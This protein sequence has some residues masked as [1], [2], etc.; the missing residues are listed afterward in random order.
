MPHCVLCKSYFVKF[1]EFNGRP[2]AGCPI[3]KSAERHRFMGYY[4]DKHIN[5]SNMSVL[6]I[7]PEKII[8]NILSKSVR[9]YICGDLN[10]NDFYPLP[11]VKLDVTDISYPDN[12]FD[13][14]IASHI[15]EH[16]SDDK[17]AL[18][19]LY[20]VLSVKGKLLIMVPQNFNSEKTDEDLN[21]TDVEI[22]KKRFG[23]HDHLR[24]YGLDL[25][26]KIKDVG[27]FVKAY[28]PSSRIKDAQKMALD[29]VEVMADS[30]IMSDNG[31]SDWDILYEC[32]KLS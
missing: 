17:K 20:R 5:K 4:F 19:E 7:A 26:Q 16:I 27:F 3:C 32:I 13:M 10:P 11:C 2:N 22:R 12:K 31:F 9:E 18:E 21:I 14:I 15:L 8:Y 23:Q 24:L 28:I 30:N 1:A 6:H 29:S 25:A